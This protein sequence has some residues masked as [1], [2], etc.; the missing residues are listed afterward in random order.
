R[1]SAPWP[2]AFR[3]RTG[4][5]PAARHPRRPGDRRPMEGTVESPAQYRPGSACRHVG[6]ESGLE[7]TLAGCGLGLG[8]P[9]E[10]AL[11]GPHR[12]VDADKAHLTGLA[13]DGRALA[14][15]LEV[16]GDRVSPWL[17]LHAH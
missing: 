13:L 2:A 7:R 9:F 6:H 14:A 10:R 5:R 17:E 11:P 4:R 12:A 16:E 3:H 15:P 8:G 1:P